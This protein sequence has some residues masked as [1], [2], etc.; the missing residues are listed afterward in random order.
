MLD[1]KGLLT[2]SMNAAKNV[3]AIATPIRFLTLVPLSELLPKTISN[4]TMN[5]TTLID[6]ITISLLLKLNEKSIFLKYSE[7]ELSRLSTPP[8]RKLTPIKI[9]LT[10]MNPVT[11]I[12]A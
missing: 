8:K 4:D 1:I 2:K 6:N 11:G 3:N 9:R 12:I 7:Y 5:K 10:S